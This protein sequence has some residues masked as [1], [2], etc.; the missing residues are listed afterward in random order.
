V[1]LAPCAGTGDAD[2][3][4]TYADQAQSWSH[5]GDGVWQYNW[6][7]AK[8][9]TGC[10]RLIVDVNDATDGRSALFTFR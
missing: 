5:Q 3:I 8:S 6:K 2:P 7:T 9:S 4:E 10:R 1:A